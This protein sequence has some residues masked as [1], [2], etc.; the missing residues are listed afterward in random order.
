MYGTH[1]MKKPT[2]REILRQLK[3]E[4]DL[5]QGGF[6]Y[7]DHYSDMN[8]DVMRKMFAREFNNDLY[9][10]APIR[11]EV[12]KMPKAEKNFFAILKKVTDVAIANNVYRNL[13]EDE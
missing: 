3:Q 6:G 5:R 11:Y 10:H 13:K 8:P 2:R 12:Y 4:E 1:I 7:G 9:T